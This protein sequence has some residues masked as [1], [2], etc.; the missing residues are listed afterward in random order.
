MQVE[1]IGGFQVI[2][3]V[4]GALLAGLGRRWRSCWARASPTRRSSA[5]TASSSTAASALPASASASSGC[6]R[7]SSPRPIAP[8]DPLAQVPVM[9]DALPG[10]IEPA[11]KQ[12]YYFG[13]DKLAR[14]VFSPHGVRQPDRAD[15]RAGGDRLCADG[16]HHARPAG[17][18]LRRPD[19][20]G[21]VVP[22][23]PRA[24]LPGHPAVLPAGDAGH[25]GHA[26]PLWAWPGCSS[27]SRSSSS[28][29]CSRRASRTGR[30][31]STCCSG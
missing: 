2:L 17:R 30:T 7:R 19:R 10:A 9:K 24:G 3:G 27:C 11:S 26:D 12:V 5:S 25:H 20:H 18:L 4:I 1:Y 28:A 6:S 31:G 16:R 13:G 22:R 8:F 29:R 23:Q 15:H 21:A 14:D